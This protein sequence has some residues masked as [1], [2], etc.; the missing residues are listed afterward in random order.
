[1]REEYV[2]AAEQLHLQKGLDH[3]FEKPDIVPGFFCGE[4]RKPRCGQVSI[5]DLFGPDMSPIWAQT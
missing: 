1:M 4:L 5:C 2:V 3:E